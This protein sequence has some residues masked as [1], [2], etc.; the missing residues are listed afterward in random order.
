MMEAKDMEQKALRFGELVLDVLL[1][2]FLSFMLV[3]TQV[4]ITITIGLT[5]FFRYILH[6]DFYS[7]EEFI[8]IF[9]FWLYMM[10][11]A[12]GSFDRSHI[13]AD[14][15]SEYIKDEKWKLRLKFIVSLI[16]TIICLI[17]NYWAYH[18]LVWGIVKGATT[19]AW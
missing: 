1:P 11:G 3:A 19:I 9:A 17:I 12:Y 8:L 7:I 15:M 13:T 6:I 14:I 5:V 4:L 2:K 16:T 18:Y 10:G